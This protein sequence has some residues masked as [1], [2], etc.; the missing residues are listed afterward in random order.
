MAKSKWRRANGEE[1]T[2]K[3]KGRR[4]KGFVCARIP[5]GCRS[6]ATGE[7]ANPWY[8]VK[9]SQTREAGDADAML[10]G[11]NKRMKIERDFAIN[12]CLKAMDIH[13]LSY[14]P[15]CVLGETS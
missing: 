2:A 15:D 7:S 4:A 13:P 6:L 8:G 12:P 10:T 1:Q 9:A 14:Y 3:S 11:I 5:K